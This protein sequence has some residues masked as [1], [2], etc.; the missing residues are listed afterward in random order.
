M[1]MKMAVEKPRAVDESRLA[2]FRRSLTPRDRRSLWGMTGFIILLHVVGFG[3]LFG[4]VVPH[5]F[6]RRG[7]YGWD[8]PE[9]L[10]GSLVAQIE[11]RFPER[12]ES[13]ADRRSHPAMRLA[14]ALVRVSANELVPRGER[15]VVL[16][17]G[18]DQYDPSPGSAATDPLAAFL[19]HALPPGVSF[20]HPTHLIRFA[21]PR[22][23]GPCGL[24]FTPPLIS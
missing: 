19:P 9:K 5:H 22:V 2:R 24:L 18:L 6:I 8:D 1:T 10:V 23:R 11:E 13:L 15:L 16:I 21:G 3:V 4:F 20:S 14:A 17:D 7:Q 12:T